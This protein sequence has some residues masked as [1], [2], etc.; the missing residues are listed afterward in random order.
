MQQTPDRIPITQIVPTKAYGQYTSLL[1]L[2]HQ[3]VIDANFRQFG[4][5]SSAFRFQSCHHFR[6]IIS[7]FCQDSANSKDEY[8]AIP[9][10][11]TAVYKFFGGGAIGLFGKSRHPISRKTAKSANF[12]ALFDV[13][14]TSRSITRFDSQSGDRTFFRRQIRRRLQSLD[15]LLWFPNPVIR[16]EKPDNC[17]LTVTLR[18]FDR[19]PSH[20][21]RSIPAL[22]FR[23]QILGR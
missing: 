8:S 22:R 13:A 19:T 18:N 15:K 9:T 1:R 20:R 10:K 4:V 12:F 23:Q 3:R 16:R 5:S 7:Q 11:L 17:I 21:R 2:L 14:V 6:Y